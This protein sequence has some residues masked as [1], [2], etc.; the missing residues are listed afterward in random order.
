MP[1]C[2]ANT[3]GATKAWL[4]GQPQKDI[5]T[6]RLPSKRQVLQKFL[7]HHQT[8]K[9]TVAQAIKMTIPAVL[10]YW[11]KARVPAQR[12]DNAERKLKKLHQEYADLR[13]TMNSKCEKRT[14]SAA[15]FESDLDDIFDIAKADA[16]TAI[17]DEEDK[18]FL[19]LQR[20][21]LSSS[22]FGP[23]DRTLAMREVRK[24]QRVAA[25][26]NYRQRA[27]KQ[28][29]AEAEQAS[30]EAIMSSSSS[31]GDSSDSDHEYKSPK[32]TRAKP[33][34]TKM[35]AIISPEV[36]SSLDR[37][38]ISSRSAALVIGATVQAMGQDPDAT[39]ASHVTIWRKRKTSRQALA[40]NDRAEFRVDGPVCL[41]WDGKL[42]PTITDGREKVDRVAIIVT[43]GEQEQLLGVPSIP[44]GTGKAQA[45]VCLKTLDEWGLRDQLTGLVF[46]TTSS[47]TGLTRGAC[48][49]IE[50]AVNRPL[51]WIACRHHV[52]EVVLSSVFSSEM[53]KSTGPENLLFKQ[54]RKDWS[55]IDQSRAS[56]APADV[57]REFSNLS[58]EKA[59][60]VNALQTGSFPRSDYRELLQLCAVFLGAVSPSDVTFKAPGALHNA[61]WMAKAIY[62]LK[63]YIFRDQLSL[64]SKEDGVRQVGLFVACC[65]TRFWHEAPLAVRAPLND[66]SFIRALSTFPNSKVATA[67]VKAMKR[68]LWFL[69]EELIGLT[70]FDDRV[71]HQQKQKIVDNLKR[72][73]N[74]AEVQKRL[75]GRTFDPALPLEDYVTEKTTHLFDALAT[76]GKAEAEI[77][78][79]KAPAA[80]S[81]DPGYLRLKQRAQMLRVTNDCAERGIALIQR[82]NSTITRDEDQKQYLLRVVYKHRKEKPTPS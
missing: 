74:R 26:D 77:F 62:C 14:I 11:E 64:A 79:S 75:D 54:F 31:D 21:D 56:P 68:H 35:S 27:L 40:E 43:S 15:M 69:S 82:Y 1:K 55:S 20:E 39:T 13:K 23:V 29:A 51:L 30:S 48:A 61:R 81:E 8:E 76:N 4:I 5:T 46:D 78:M 12:V 28:A 67:G 16:M 2:K 25:E 59:F 50:N 70:L 44:H 57:L 60:I 65:Y 58:E 37:A 47:N 53:G 73:S 38:N 42:L 32:P 49:I 72:P 66:L 80:W 45:D 17:P 34:R 33:K 22:S 18:E 71:S 36:A 63:M 10:E 52:L 24:S 41:H 6:A 19:R 7:F 9:Q 3:R